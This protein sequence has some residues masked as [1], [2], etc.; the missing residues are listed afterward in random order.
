MPTL[1]E[2]HPSLFKRN[3]AICQG[4]NILGS[5][6]NVAKCMSIKD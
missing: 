5:E 4:A 3:G 2:V 1:S 6:A